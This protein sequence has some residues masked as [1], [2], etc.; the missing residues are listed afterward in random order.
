MTA[1]VTNNRSIKC[2]FVYEKIWEK[3]GGLRE[4]RRGGKYL[5][6]RGTSTVYINSA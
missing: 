5:L 3:K 4:G 1:E 6:E 2:V